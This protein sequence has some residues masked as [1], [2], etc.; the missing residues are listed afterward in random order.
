MSRKSNGKTTYT[1][2]KKSTTKTHTKTTT[3]ANTTVINNNNN[4]HHNNS[5]FVSNGT[6]GNDHDHDAK[7][8]VD[9]SSPQQFKRVMPAIYPMPNWKRDPTPADVERWEAAASA[10]ADVQLA[11]ERKEK[12]AQKKKAEKKNAKKKK[13]R[14]FSS[15]GGGDINGGGDAYEENG[16]DADID[17]VE[18]VKKRRRKI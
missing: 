15:I 3:V 5:F 6:Y 8:S 1:N 10:I 14:K 2:V 17:G 11:Q 18:R 7:D 4:Y 13:A 12:D 9:F 16:Y